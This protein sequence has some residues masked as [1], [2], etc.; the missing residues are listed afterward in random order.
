MKRLIMIL[1]L[2]PVL[3][4]AEGTST[5]MAAIEITGAKIYAPVKGSNSTAG[6]GTIK[7]NTD[8]AVTLKISKVSPFKAVETHETLEKQGKM[9]M[10]KV[11]SFSIAAK[12][13]FEL[14]PGGNHIML[15]DP[16]REVKVGEELKVEF[17]VDSKPVEMTF[18][19]EARN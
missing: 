10:K 8:K 12:S 5:A 19:V 4:L 11:E 1:C 17:M 14:K 13:S 15:F 9:S 3:A 2:L 16:S 6:Y 7:N 18:K